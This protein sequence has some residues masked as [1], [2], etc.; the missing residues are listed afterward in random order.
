MSGAP[1][2]SSAPVVVVMGVSGTGK[3]TI[4]MLVAE[5]LEVDFIEGDAHHP[6]ANIAKMSAG[7]PLTDEDRRPWLERLAALAAE[8][9]DAGRAVVMTCSALK[10]DYR[11]VLRSRTPAGTTFFVHLHGDLD[12]LTTRMQERVKHFMPPSLL[13]SQL[14]TLEPLGDDEDG[15]TIDVASSPSE[16]AAE[17][18]AALGPVAGGPGSS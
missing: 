4:G 1:G 17:V 8:E 14:G 15:A 5:A 18:L 13:A 12:V 3:S 10:R 16:V 6:D 11:D 2:S 9:H 7:T